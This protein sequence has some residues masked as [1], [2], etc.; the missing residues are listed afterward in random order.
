MKLCV[1]DL[2]ILR[3]RTLNGETVL[4]F[5]VPGIVVGSYSDCSG[6]GFVCVKRYS[7]GVCT[8]QNEWESANYF[9]KQEML[10]VNYPTCI[11]DLDFANDLAM[12]ADL[13]CSVLC[14][15]FAEISCRSLRPIIDY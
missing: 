1:K 5:R 15:I 14:R 4:M 9:G 8:Y 11:T 13:L 10:Q 7:E 12:T 6:K 2:W 3:R